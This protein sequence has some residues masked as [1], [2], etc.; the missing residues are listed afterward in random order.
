MAL[1]VILEYKT[2]SGKTGRLQLPVEIWMNTPYH[3]FFLPENE[4]LA[5]VVIDPDKQFPDI[6]PGNNKWNK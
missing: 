2:V 1:P 5:S 4:R 6:N 3:T